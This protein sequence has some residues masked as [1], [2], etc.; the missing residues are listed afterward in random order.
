MKNTSLIFL[1]AFLGFTQA[2]SQ[3]KNSHYKAVE[4]LMQ[5]MKAEKGFQDNLNNSLNLQM[6]QIPQASQYD[7][8]IK[9]FVSK[10]LNWD[11]VKED[12]IQVYISEFSEKEIKQL[13]KFYK[14]PIGQKL[15]DRQGI[16]VSKSSEI[17]MK[18]MMAHLPELQEII[19]R[20]NEK[21]DN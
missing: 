4:E 16:L 21:K 11:A 14:T 17:T 12:L 2:Y 3:E 13:T 7:G 15:A 6:K 5:V 1:L 9:E 20:Q 10:Y 8:A 19:M 18:R